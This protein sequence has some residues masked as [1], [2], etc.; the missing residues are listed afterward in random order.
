MTILDRLDSRGH[1]TDPDEIAEADEAVGT[2]RHGC[3]EWS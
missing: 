2:S 1:L 3:E